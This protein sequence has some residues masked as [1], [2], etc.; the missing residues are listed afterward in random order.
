M[1]KG[2][3]YGPAVLGKEEYERQ[4]AEH[5]KSAGI[6]GPA[7]TEEPKYGPAVGGP[8]D[9]TTP[10][11]LGDKPPKE[12]SGLSVKKLK[13]ILEGDPGLNDQILEVELGRAEGPRK[14]ALRELAKFE[15]LKESP[16]AGFIDRVTAILEGLE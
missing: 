6:Y 12:A 11:F 7:F 5:K 15:R 14:S 1:A 10:G 16:R 3:L 2:P 4:L 8:G 13:E 9:A